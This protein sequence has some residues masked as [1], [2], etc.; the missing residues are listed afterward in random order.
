MAGCAHEKVTCRQITQNFGQRCCGI[1]AH[2][3]RLGWIKMFIFQ[4]Q[5]YVINS[6]Y[7]GLVI[8]AKPCLKYE[9]T[10]IVNSLF[11]PRLKE[12]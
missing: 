9:L 1:A 6:E 3:R 12:V 4:N 11:A 5:L 8:A 10:V 2:H 7:H